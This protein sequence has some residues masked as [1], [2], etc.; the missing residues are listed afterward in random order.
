MLVVKQ[1]HSIIV[2]SRYVGGETG[3]LK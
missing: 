3:S 2:L 1:A